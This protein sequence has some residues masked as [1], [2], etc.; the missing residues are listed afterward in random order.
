MPRVVSIL[1]RIGVKKPKGV[2][3]KA[4]VKAGKEWGV[5]VPRMVLDSDQPWPRVM[6]R[7]LVREAAKR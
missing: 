5:R 6:R 1:D 7:L 4:P 2:K 3:S